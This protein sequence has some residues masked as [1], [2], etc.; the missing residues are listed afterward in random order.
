MN[1]M[2][3]SINNFTRC[4]KSYEPP[5]ASWKKVDGSEEPPRGFVYF[6]R[7]GEDLGM[8]GVQYTGFSMTPELVEKMIREM[9]EFFPFFIESRVEPYE[10]V[11]RK[12]PQ[13]KVKSRR[14]V[15]NTP[16]YNE[17]VKLSQ[18]YAKSFF[19]G[20]K[21]YRIHIEKAFWYV[22]EENREL[23]T[24]YVAR[25]SKIGSLE[26][27]VVLE[28]G[29]EPAVMK[30]LIEANHEL[31]PPFDEILLQEG[32]LTVVTD[33]KEKFRWIKLLKSFLLR[34]RKPGFGRI[35]ITTPEELKAKSDALAANKAKTEKKRL[36]NWTLSLKSVK[37][38]IILKSEVMEEAFGC[39][40]EFNTPM[41]SSKSFGS[42][43]VLTKEGSE[44]VLDEMKKR[45]A[46]GHLRELNIDG[47]KIYE[48]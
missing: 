31:F 21:G 47:V 33:E 7:F 41:L 2:N 17:W 35:H 45:G 10:D 16:H 13:L 36:F 30:E 48:G 4:A 29:I 44:A 11:S 9:K 28:Q 24:G 1:N 19:L 15:I 23:P 42:F 22:D 3:K 38:N 20:N 5:A 43:I 8:G 34:L 18:E 14:L 40:R 26:K 27:L 39:A 6:P 46:I 25:Y 37:P 32:R 12:N